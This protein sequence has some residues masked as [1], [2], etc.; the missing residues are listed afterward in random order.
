MGLTVFLRHTLEV[1]LVLTDIVM[2]HSG[3][4]MVD[5]I[6]RFEPEMP[7]VFMTGTAGVSDIPEHLKR[8][9]LLEKPFS[10]ERLSTVVKE[11]LRVKSPQPSQRIELHH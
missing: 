1:D 3:V 10:V 9:H 8:C 7:I 6:L 2:P 4:E 5:E 11:C